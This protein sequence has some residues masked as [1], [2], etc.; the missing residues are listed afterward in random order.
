LVTARFF[1]GAAFFLVAARLFFGAAFFRVAVF[2]LVVERFTR[3]F[4]LA[5]FFVAAFLTAIYTPSRL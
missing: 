1:F 5:R 3:D 4:A 2:V